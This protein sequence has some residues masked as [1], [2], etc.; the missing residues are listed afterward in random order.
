VN[1]TSKTR[2]SEARKM[3][4]DTQCKLPLELATA[5]SV[6][7]RLLDERL[8]GRVTGLYLVGSVALD[9]YQPG[10]SDI[11]FV[12]VTDTPL[13]NAE[14]YELGSL[15]VNLR[16]NSAAARIRRRIRHVGAVGGGP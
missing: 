13:S 2:L 16:R 3:D 8:P 15:H 6:Y 14:L 7:L 12:A 10:Q 1:A 11:D 5:T 9:A 4:S